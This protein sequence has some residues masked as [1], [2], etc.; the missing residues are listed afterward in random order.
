MPD[1]F[2]IFYF[3]KKM[4]IYF[5]LRRIFYWSRTLLKNSYNFSRQWTFWHSSHYGIEFCLIRLW[6]GMKNV[7]ALQE[8]KKAYGYKNFSLAAP[9]PDKFSWICFDKK[10][11]SWGSV[12]LETPFFSTQ[13]NFFLST[14][15]MGKRAI[16]SL[17]EMSFRSKWT[18]RKN[19]HMQMGDLFKYLYLFTPWQKTSIKSDL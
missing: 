8:A 10:L 3:E 15:K 2:E 7:T 9:L 12:C 17:P 1:A 4:V 19:F 6:H 11:K 13:I 14:L 18:T 16:K 5:L